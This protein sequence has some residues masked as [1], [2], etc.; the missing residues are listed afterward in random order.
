MTDSFDR[1]TGRRLPFAAIRSGKTGRI[2]REAPRQGNVRIMSTYVTSLIHAA[3]R[4][5]AMRASDGLIT[6]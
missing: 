2:L 4:V 6:S 3:S 1:A 5:P